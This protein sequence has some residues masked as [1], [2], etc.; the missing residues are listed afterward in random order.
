MAEAVMIAL[1]TK[2]IGRQDAHE[3]MRRLSMKAMENKTTL[4]EEI[5]R[6]EH[7]SGLFSPEELDALMDPKNYIGRAEEIVD[8][9][10]SKIR[11]T[12]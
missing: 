8:T 6:D 12:G 5:S 2:D 1:V 10:I 3:M 4:K 11:G 7:I 9:V